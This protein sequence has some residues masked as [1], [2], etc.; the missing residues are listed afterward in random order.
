MVVVVAVVLIARQVVTV[1]VVHHHLA[2]VVL[3]L[4][5]H[6]KHLHI[7]KHPKHPPTVRVVE[8]DL[9]VTMKDGVHY[10]VVY[11]HDRYHHP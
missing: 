7:V 10:Q 9:V 1:Q 5:Q 8:N 6:R 3:A 11:V 4:T 2:A